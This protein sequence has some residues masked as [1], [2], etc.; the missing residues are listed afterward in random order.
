MR[1]AALLLAALMLAGCGPKPDA[2]EDYGTR[3]VTLPGGQQVRA[4]VLIN[5]QDLARGMMF[6]DSLA[7]DR[8]MLFLHREAG[9]YPYWMYQVRIPLDIVWMDPGRRVVE[10]AAS[11]PP[12]RTEPGQ[13]PTYGGHYRAQYVLELAGG[14]AAK[15][16]IKAGDTLEF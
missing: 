16:G 5:P 12:C 3:M 11:A 4:E 6:R 14:M 8:G 2:V 15:Y 10:I 7:P 9:E 13:C 1:F